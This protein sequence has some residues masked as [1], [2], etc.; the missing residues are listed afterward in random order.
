MAT[1]PTIPSQNIDQAGSGT[2]VVVGSLTTLSPQTDDVIVIIGG[3][4]GNSAS[5]SVNNGTWTH[6]VNLDA[7]E[8]ELHV[9]TRRAGAS[10]SGNVTVS[11]TGIEGYVWHIFLVRGVRT[12]SGITFGTTNSG[13]STTATALSV[14]PTTDNNLIVAFFAGDRDRITNDQS[15]GGTGWTTITLHQSGGANGSWSGFSTRADHSQTASTNATHT[16]SSGDG[17]HGV[18]AIFIPDQTGGGGFAHSQAV[19][20]S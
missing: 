16:L 18:Q 3:L 13:S 1:P 5:P 19:I 4:D 8:C 17:W 15:T 6:N 20:I 12:T 11:W 9:F 14:T 7:N 10:E 2:S